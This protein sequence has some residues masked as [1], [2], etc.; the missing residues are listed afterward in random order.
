VI[1]LNK[2]GHIVKSIGLKGQL[3]VALDRISSLDGVE[4]LFIDI[5]GSKVPFYIEA[6]SSK[7][8]HQISLEDVSSPEAVSQFISQDIYIENRGK[9]SLKAPENRKKHALDD[10]IGFELQDM[11]KSVLGTVHDYIDYGM[12]QVLKVTTLDGQEVVVPFHNDLVSELLSTEKK[13]IMDL[14]KGLF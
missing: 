5:E 12:H 2:V 8:K 3:L 10:L 14:P 1:Q 7:N 4:Y 6:Y 9:Q 13:L 11:E